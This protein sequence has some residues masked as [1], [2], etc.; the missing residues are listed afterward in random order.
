MEVVSYKLVL[1]VEPQMFEQCLIVNCLIDRC[2]I[3]CDAGSLR[4]GGEK[5]TYDDHL[6]VIGDAAGK[7]CGLRKSA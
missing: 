3:V 2:L 1:Y 7:G 6:L 5:N 4:V